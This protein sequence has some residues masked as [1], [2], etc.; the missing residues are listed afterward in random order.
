LWIFAATF[1]TGALV[2]DERRQRENRRECLC[3]LTRKQ[4]TDD[5]VVFE[6]GNMSRF[7]RNYHA[8]AILSKPGKIIVLLFFSGLLAFGIFGAVNLSVEDT[9][10]EFVPE[11]SYLKDYLTAF[12]EYFPNEGIDLYITFESGPQIFKSR[13]ELADLATRLTGLS[14][15]PPYIAEPVSEESYR[16]AM[17][18]FR[19]Y[20]VENGSSRI[21][22]VTL[23]EDN[24]PTNEA[25]F[26]TALSLYASFTGPGAMYAQDVVFSS[27]ATL[28]AY[29][30]KSEYV[31]LTKEDRSGKI[32][33]D[34]DRQIEAMEGTRELANSWTD[35]QPAF[36]YS[37][38]FTTIEGFQ[39]IQ[40]E[41]F[42]NVGLAIAAVA[43]IIF[44]TVASPVT[45]LL[46]TLNVAFCL[47]EILGFM[48]ALGFAI[49]SVSVINLVLAVGLSVDYSAHIGH[50]FMVKGG[51]DKDKRAL[52]ALA[53]MG[54]AV[55]A[56]G[57]STFLAVAVLLFSN[58]YVFFVLSRQFCLTV[59]LGLAHGLIL[60]PVMLALMGP[61]PFSSAEL[62][63]GEEDAAKLEGKKGALGHSETVPMDQTGHA[64][65]DDD[66]EQGDVDAEKK[67]KKNKSK[68]KSVKSDEVID[69]TA[70]A[71]EEEKKL[72]KK[73]SKTK[74]K[75][76]NPQNQEEATMK[77]KKSKKSM[78]DGADGELEEVTKMKKKSQKATESN[79]DGAVEEEK[80][81]KK[82]KSKKTIE[83]NEDGEVV[84]KKSKKKKSK[85]KSVKSLKAEDDGTNVVG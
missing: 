51:P 34:A 7:F 14:T 56:G 16:N 29:R 65:S 5:D 57:T 55:L 27:N 32:I 13:Q 80:K 58:S 2:L 6:E 73:K 78:E 52:E 47:A 41:L 66:P 18:G 81:L 17:T 36:P 62:Y 45:A 12:D 72:K 42:R 26:Y 9:E 43:I 35:L 31:R 39:V 71:G 38:K 4:H 40:E 15:E 54:A 8:P 49:D 67:P 50:S 68:R 48:W 70:V 75:S 84:E 23:G 21:G 85:K 10:R 11:E 79:D 24:W 44:I 76:G 63:D 82:K 46:I 74:P 20:L 83:T 33:D 77:K 28:E 25:D 61:K 30:V 60:L 59:V 1:F 37:P 19:K 3:C 22:N 69:K 53:D 64:N